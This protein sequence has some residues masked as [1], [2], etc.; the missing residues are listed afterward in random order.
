MRLALQARRRQRE[1]LV[2]LNSG[3][4]TVLVDEAEEALLTQDRS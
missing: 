4:A 1:L 3:G 2:I